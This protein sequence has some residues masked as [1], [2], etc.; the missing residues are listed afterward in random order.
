MNRYPHAFSGGQRQRI[1]IGRALVLHPRFIVCDEPVSALDVSIQAQ[2]L[3]LLQD[4]QSQFGLTYLFVAHNLSVVKH[5]SN[6]VAV[7]Y[8]GKIVEMAPTNKL[9]AFP[10]HPY[11]EALLS[12]V[13]NPDPTLQIEPVILPGEVA[14]AARPA[15]RLLLPPA[16]Q[17]PH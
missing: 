15:Q 5:I 8:V 4:L 9:Y 6:R 10:K 11:T 3:N 7:M 13:P 2:I 16:L 1:C 14:D 12:A 17:I